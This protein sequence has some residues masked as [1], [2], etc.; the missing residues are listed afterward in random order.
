MAIVQ[1][2]DHVRT[3]CELFTV[4]SVSFLVGYSHKSNMMLLLRH[5]VSMYLLAFHICSVL[6]L[7]V[8]RAE[9]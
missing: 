3:A 9:K 1:Y 5:T 2:N 4:S 8:K 6:V 7:V